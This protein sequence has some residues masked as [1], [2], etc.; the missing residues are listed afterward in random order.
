[1]PKIIP[2]NPKLK[3]LAKELRNKS[4]LAEILLWKKIKGKAL[5]V[6]FHRQIPIDEYIVDFYCHELNLA[7]EIDGNSHDQ[8]FE[9]D[10]QRQKKLELL[11][12]KVIRFNDLEVKKDIKN[13]L[14][15]IEI[16]I[17]ERKDIPLPPSKG[18]LV[19][20]SEN[21]YTKYN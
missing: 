15:A 21:F 11:G 6:E 8:K 10:E 4:T 16:F 17:D 12:I 1:M 18:E 9:Y 2:Y 14:R 5:N 19:R 13:V 7:I 3:K 20:N